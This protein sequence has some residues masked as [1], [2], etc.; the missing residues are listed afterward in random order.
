MWQLLLG[1]V[2]FMGIHSV[3]MV[4]PGFRQAQLSANEGRWKG[5]YSLLSLVGLALIVWGWWTYRPQAPEIYT[6]PDWGRYAAAGL[7]WLGFI[8]NVSAYQPTGRIKEALQHPFLAGVIL[9]AIGHLLAN[10]DLASLLL[11]GGFL[12]Y[13]L[14]NRVAVAFRPDPAPTFV[15]YRGDIVA[16]VAGTLVFALFAFWLH[17]FLFGVNPL[18]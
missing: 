10:G 8:A 18:D 12:L 1:I 9:W 15:S 4:A 16:V 7:L 3:R 14:V 17:G 11:F 13:A 5:M 2:L 6:P